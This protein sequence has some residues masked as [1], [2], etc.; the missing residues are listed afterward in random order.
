MRRPYTKCCV[1]GPKATSCTV[2]VVPTVNGIK[3]S[4]LVLQYLVL[5]PG[6]QS[7]NILRRSDSR[8]Q[9]YYS[10][11]SRVV[12][13]LV[14]AT[15][16]SYVRIRFRIYSLLAIQTVQLA[17]VHKIHNSTPVLNSTVVPCSTTV[18]YSSTVEDVLRARSTNDVCNTKAISLC[19][20]HRI[21]L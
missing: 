15:R 14:I 21:Q 9:K 6:S 2:P 8:V 12:L 20:E 3:W 13:V 19:H 17:W 11:M 1:T 7:L 16:Q 4:L 10:T 5:V 18:D